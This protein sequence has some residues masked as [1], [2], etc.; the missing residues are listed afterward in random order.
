MTLNI[1]FFSITIKKRKV[2]TEEAIHQEMVEK[3]YEQNKDRQA[4]M[5][6]GM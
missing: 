4:S 6:R 5:Y 2:S 3:L 1:I